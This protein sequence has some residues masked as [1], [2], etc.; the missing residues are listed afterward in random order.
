MICHMARTGSAGPSSS[1][2]TAGDAQGRTRAVA[3][4][5]NTPF[6]ARRPR[7]PSAA[8]WGWAAPRPG[9][10]RQVPTRGAVLSGIVLSSHQGSNFI[11]CAVGREANIKTRATWR[12]PPARTS[13]SPA[14]SPHLP[15]S[16]RQPVPAFRLHRPR[17][18]PPPPTEGQVHI[19]ILPG[20][21]KKKS[22]P[23]PQA[24]WIFK[25]NTGERQR[26]TRRTVL[27]M[28]VRSGL[29]YI[30]CLLAGAPRSPLFPELT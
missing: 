17:L 11:T 1:A 10:L 23:S 3:G 16:P 28:E 30:H 15:C 5:G 12:C 9:E 19:A 6:P 14:R 13:G 7:A 29:Q 20:T 4:G 18:R 27:W 25:V 24:L 8:P 22:V 21:P 2:S 26:T